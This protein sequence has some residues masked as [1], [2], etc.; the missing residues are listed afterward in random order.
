MAEAAANNFNAT[1]DEVNLEIN[2]LNAAPSNVP[3]VAV[4]LETNETDDNNEQQ[5]FE[6]VEETASDVVTHKDGVFNC[7]LENCGFK[8][9]S[10]QSLI[11][12]RGKRHKQ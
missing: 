9:I 3:T 8:G 7:S 10:Y 12:Q 6:D 5:I 2:Y 4:N 1:R 11:V